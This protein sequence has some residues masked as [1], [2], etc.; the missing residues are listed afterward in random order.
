MGIG[1]DLAAPLA[2]EHA[3]VIDNFKEQLLITMVK[4][5]GG[6]ISVPIDEVDDTSQDLLMMSIENGSFH[7]EIKKKQ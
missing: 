5:L 2:P 7:F 3:K 1:I 4:R 6:T